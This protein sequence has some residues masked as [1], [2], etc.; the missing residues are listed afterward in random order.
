MGRKP[1]A[2]SYIFT[3]VDGP[4]LRERAGRPGRTTGRDWAPTD[5]S[6]SGS[7]PV[8]ST[9]RGKRL[10]DST[11]IYERRPRGFIYLVIGVTRAS[12][13]AVVGFALIIAA[14][15]VWYSASV[16][17]IS[18]LLSRNYAPDCNNPTYS[19]DMLKAVTSEVFWVL[20]H[21]RA[22]IKCKK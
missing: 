5:S 14:A 16:T 3:D 11:A 9:W 10:T 13:S 22:E 4:I 1:R 15:A 18:P 8:R 6:R 19:V 7:G 17:C 20:K 12:S 21:P 2:G